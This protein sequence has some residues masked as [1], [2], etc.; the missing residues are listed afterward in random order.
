MTAEETLVRLVDELTHLTIT[1]IPSHG[2]VLCA[3]EVLDVIERAI[4][5]YEQTKEPV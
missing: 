5:S 4:T 2:D 1:S 3:D